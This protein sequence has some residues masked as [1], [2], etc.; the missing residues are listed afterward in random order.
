MSSNTI[1]DKYN[2]LLELNKKSNIY[3]GVGFSIGII[4]IISLYAMEGIIDV[5]IEEITNYNWMALGI[6]LLCIPAGISIARKYYDVQLKKKEEVFF[7]FYKSYK[8][9]QIYLDRKTNEDKNNAKKALNDLQYMF[10]KWYTPEAPESISEIPSSL[11]SIFREKIIPLVK[12]GEMDKIHDL[13]EYLN[14]LS[15]IAFQRQITLEDCQMFR[16]KLNSL[17]IMMEE[18]SAL[19]EKKKIQRKKKFAKH[20][21]WFVLFILVGIGAAL[22]A[23]LIGGSI[24]T[25][26]VMGGAFSAALI[27]G[28]IFRQR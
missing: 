4:A 7:K 21:G 3:W 24:D 12:K 26:I 15:N 1:G 5:E 17:K 19:E 18:K 9:L 11:T 28:Y 10:A 6:F 16:E 8:M 27:A 25:Q 14:E 22:I 2:I 23:R 20:V 13:S